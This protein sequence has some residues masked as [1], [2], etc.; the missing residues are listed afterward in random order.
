MN[1]MPK[2]N[3]EK[4]SNVT[5]PTSDTALGLDLNFLIHEKE[6]ITLPSEISFNGDD[7]MVDI[8]EDAGD[9]KMCIS[10]LV[11]EPSSALNLKNGPSNEEQTKGKDIK[12]DEDRGKCITDI[13]SMTDLSVTLESIKPSSLPPLNVL[14]EKN[15][16]TIV[17]HFAKGKPREDVQVVVVTTISK[18]SSSLSNFHFQA[19]VPKVRLHL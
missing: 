8:S 17:F 15:G 14:E 7:C 13:K 10:E 4:L 6:H 16:I 9:A 1:L 18:N 2:Q 12:I 5:P 3:L 19:V 11:T